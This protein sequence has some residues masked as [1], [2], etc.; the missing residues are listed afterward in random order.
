[1]AT[2]KTGASADAEERLKALTDSVPLVSTLPSPVD[3]TDQQLDD[4]T[5][6]CGLS[7]FSA[8]TE[9]QALFWAQRGT[10]KKYASGEV[11]LEAGAPG[12]SMAVILSGSVRI[13]ILDD[14]G[15][16]RFV[17]HLGPGDLFGEIAILTGE[18]GLRRSSPTAMPIARCC[19]STKKMLN[20]SCATILRSRGF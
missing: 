9:H 17:A 16:E 14:N 4:A 12:D 6:L 20:L 11:I 8:L 18:P 7:S 2:I 15:F 3:E 13:P 1:M 5:F 10:R 19:T